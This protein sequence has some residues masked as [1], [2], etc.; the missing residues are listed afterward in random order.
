MSATRQKKLLQHLEEAAAKVGLHVNES[1]TKYMTFNQTGDIKS[2]SGII[3]EQEQDFKYLGSWIESS[4]KD[5]KT[6]IGQAWSALSKLD[7]I[8]SSQLSR[9]MKINFFHSTV[10]SVLLYGSDTWTLTKEMT[11]RLDGVY[12]RMLRRVLGYTWKDYVKNEDLYKNL[13]RISDELR[14]RRVQFAG[15]CWR[16][17]EIIHDLLFWEPS[18]G[19]RG[20]PRNNYI[21]QLEEDIKVKKEEMCLMMEDRDGWRRVV[22]EVRA[23]ARTD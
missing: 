22:H 18:H 12:T 19:K 17:N 16:S 5:L 3:L 20:R 9:E 21:R 23:G 2:R 8:W 15:H 14:A 10:I 13:P 1:K 6:R 11:R 7:T 4:R